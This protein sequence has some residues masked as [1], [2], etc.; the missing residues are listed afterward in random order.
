MSGLTSLFRNARDIRSSYIDS[1][2][3]TECALATTR[4]TDLNHMLK[5]SGAP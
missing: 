2:F 5:E 3:K 1:S 4:F